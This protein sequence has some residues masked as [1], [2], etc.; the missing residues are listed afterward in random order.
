MGAYG[1]LL[2]AALVIVSGVIAYVGDILGRWMG[3]RRMTIFG[4]RPRHTAIVTSI[5]AGMVIA[6]LTLASA[7]VVS[8]NVRDG[9][10]KV[11]LLR[12][13]NQ[14]LRAQQRTLS[15]ELH[16]TG[17]KLGRA[18]DTLRQANTQLVTLNASLEKVE[19]EVKSTQAK[20]ADARRELAQKRAEVRELER[21]SLRKLAEQMQLGRWRE[22]LLGK[23]LETVYT[24]P[25]IFRVNDPILATTIDGSQTKFVIGRELRAF[26]QQVDD[27]ARK[28]GAGTGKDGKAI[29][30][31]AFPATS[32]AQVLKA[33][34]DGIAETKGRVVARA[35][36]VGNAVEGAP[37]Q[38][39]FQ[40]FRNQLVFHKGDEIA[41]AR[42]DAGLPE[43]KLLLAMVEL[44]RGRVAQVARSKGVMPT[45]SRAVGSGSVPLLPQPLESVGAMSVDDMLATVAKIKAAGGVVTVIARAAEDTWTAG[46]LKIELVVAS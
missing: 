10:T 9:L 14:R 21:K 43:S 18:Q 7:M 41:R 13:Q 29:S 45:V 2:I 15:R 12:G 22:G 25:V 30:I 3:K 16:A 44:L 4:L 5:A 42:V 40:L 11:G 35:Y 20:L 33:V 26:V 37:V 24:K 23:T 32:E 17:K 38:V 34:T 39:D 19:K 27:A 6:V 8:Q 28:A 36:S 1:V 31:G 46:P